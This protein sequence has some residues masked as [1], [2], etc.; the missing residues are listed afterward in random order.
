M[1]TGAAEPEKLLLSMG[2][3]GVHQSPSFMLFALDQKVK[4]IWQKLERTQTRDAF[5]GDFGSPL[6]GSRQE[7]CA[8]ESLSLN[9]TKL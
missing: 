6:P 7:D 4:D 9:A 1:D 8:S 3:R 2:R 5:N